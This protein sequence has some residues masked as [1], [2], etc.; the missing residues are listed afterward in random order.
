MHALKL[1]AR[2]N[3]ALNNVISVHHCIHSC[4]TFVNLIVGVMATQ[5][6]DTFSVV[7]VVH[8]YHVY[9]SVRT[10]LLG[11]RLLARTETGYNHNKVRHLRRETCVCNFPCE[12]L[13]TLWHFIL[14]GGLVTCEVT[15]KRKLRNGLEMG[16]IH[17]KMFFVFRE[18][19]F[20]CFGIN[21][22]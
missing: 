16:R 21:S 17:R 5:T 11:E 4:S 19:F 15:G 20:C 13:R 9:T 2:R 22:L 6:E 3:Y 12:L 10:P 7:S 14:H 1:A 8:G 18:K